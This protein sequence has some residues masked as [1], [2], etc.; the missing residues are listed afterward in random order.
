MKTV[1]ALT[2]KQ[3]E[4]TLYCFA[5]SAMELEPL[6]YVE[7]ATRDKKRGLQRVT[8]AS[9]LREIGE[10]L[11]SG[12]NALLP[13]NI[14]LNLKPD[15]TIS[16]EGDTGIVT[17]TF[18]SDEGEYAFIV[19]GQHRLFSF[20]DTYR[21]LPD[22][23]IFELPVVALHNATE[24]VVGATFVA[25]NCNQKPVNRDLL[26]QMKAILGLLDSD[27]E[28]TSIELIHSLDEDPSSPLQGRILRYPQERGK[29]IKTNQLQPVILGLLSPGGCLHDKTQA[30]RKRILIAY[31]DA[32]KTT[33][34]NAWAD[35]KAKS[36]SLLQTSGLQLALSLVP[37]AMQRCDFYESFSYTADTFERQIA[38][39]AD[40][41]ILGDWK[42]AAVEDA[43]ST[44]AKRKNFLGQL[45]EALR[46]KA[47][48]V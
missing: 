45:K 31:L 13:N 37:D 42:K 22:D 38:P 36:Y 33:F 35:D 27:I 2:L 24:E 32:V 44:A 19:D 20:D 46:L 47:P 29:W 39:L 1:R 8:E 10:Y 11:A 40:A 28:K 23:E 12:V 30:E 14:I 43:I 34:P 4:T 41:A 25:I 48:P 9:R 7:A 21:Q 18:P 26:T 6:C 15:V 3:K 16:P 5:M 17:I